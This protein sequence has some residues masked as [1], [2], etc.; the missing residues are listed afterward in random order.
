MR[1][2]FV[3]NLVAIVV[4]LLGIFLF[5][6]YEEPSSEPSPSPNNQLSAVG[7]SQ[8]PPLPTNNYDSIAATTS[9]S[10]QPSAAKKASYGAISPASSTPPN[11]VAR[12]Q[13]PYS[14]P[15]ESFD[16][17]NVD[18][19]AALVNI[20]CQP[21]GGSLQPISGSGV[22]IDPRGI[23]L[24][25]AHVAQYVLLSESPRIDLKCVVR[26]GSPA[27]AQWQAVVLFIPP[28]WVSIHASEILNQHP[29]GTGEHDYALLY[30]VGS[31][32]GTPLPTQFPYISPDTREAIGFPG[33]QV[34][35]ASYPAEFIGG[36]AAQ[37]DLFAA[38]SITTIKQ[39]L[40]FSSGTPDL[41]SLGGIIVA[42]SGSSGGA[43]LNAWGRLIGIITTTSSGTTTASRDLRA[44]TLSYINT[45][46]ATQS[47]QDLGA[48]LQGTPT[49]E[50]ENFN[51]TTAPAL[52]NLY[53]PQLSGNQ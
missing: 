18:A 40:T 29:T 21:Q 24:T 15:S 52:V 38:S 9:T 1:R 23:I 8:N 50:V 12:I 47:G 25:N 3:L 13:N 32:A 51:K 33:D 36:I 14:T 19:R 27:R 53:I 49:Q 4:F 10:S 35:A 5:V 34:L 37:Y 28:A 44:V 6:R 11:E 7:I 26:T 20:L 42:Q 30:I 17:I 45:D 2:S 39:L 41:L 46:L 43:V 22:I 16:E 48:F 31:T